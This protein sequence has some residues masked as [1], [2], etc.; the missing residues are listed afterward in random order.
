MSKD[1]ASASLVV[2]A[3]IDPPIHWRQ[4]GKNIGPVSMLCHEL[5]LPLISVTV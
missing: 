4:V 5:G 1:I 2:L 3:R